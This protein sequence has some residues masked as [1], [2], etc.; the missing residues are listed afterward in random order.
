MNVLQLLCSIVH[1]W[2]KGIPSLCLVYTCFSA[3]IVYSEESTVLCYAPL[4]LLLRR[5][6]LPVNHCVVISA[7]LN[8]HFPHLLMQ[9]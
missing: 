2:I 1:E 8:A 7:G 6:G 5:I 4:S 9:N 3:S